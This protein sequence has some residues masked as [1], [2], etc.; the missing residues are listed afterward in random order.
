MTLRA[1]LPLACLLACGSSSAPAA[2]PDAGDAGQRDAPASP[3]EAACLGCNVD[4]A[5][6]GP[7]CGPMGNAPAYAACIARD[8]AC[9]DECLA[10][11]LCTAIADPSPSCASAFPS[12]PYFVS[13]PEA[14]PR[15]A[16]AAHQPCAQAGS[17]ELCCAH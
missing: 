14:G 3:C 16:P 1:S 13:C 7:S 6:C 11:L 17:T 4:D 15:K 5:F 10:E 8:A 12:M 9:S 2:A